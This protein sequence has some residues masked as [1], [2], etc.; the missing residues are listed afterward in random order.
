MGVSR[1]LFSIFVSAVLVVIVVAAYVLGLVFLLADIMGLASS[2]EGAF[3]EAA[4]V[5]VVTFSSAVLICK[6]FGLDALRRKIAVGM[7]WFA[8]A[9]IF[10]VIMALIALF[11]NE[12]R[13]ST[14]NFVFILM[15][16]GAAIGSYIAYIVVG[17]VV[18]FLGTQFAM[19]GNSLPK[20][21]NVLF[22]E[23]LSSGYSKPQTRAFINELN[24]VE[25]GVGLVY[26][27]LIL[28]GIPLFA[29]IGILI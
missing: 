2:I 17:M 25:G 11:Y 9:C 15:I 19:L 1:G 24:R 10:L 29:L 6:L 22:S 18:G 28:Y 27:T 7:V 20:G 12:M 16:A 8:A 4:I 14:S 26:T 13:S 5:T 23:V 21:R 3:A